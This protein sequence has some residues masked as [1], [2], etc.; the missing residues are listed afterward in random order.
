MVVLDDA[1]GDP[2]ALASGVAR[3]H[4]GDVGHVYRH[5][6]R[7]F[8]ARLPAPAVEA[9]RRHPRVRYVERDLPLHPLALQENAPWSLDRIDQR[10]TALDGRYRHWW[11]GAGVHLYVI[12]TGIEAQHPQFGGRVRHGWSAVSDGLGSGDCHGHG[13]AV[14]GA[15]GGASLGVARGAWLWSVRISGD[16]AAGMAAA[17]DAVRGL[18]WVAGNHQQPAVA[19][20]SFAG[21]PPG[22]LS[23]TFSRT[24]E[25][26][27]RGLVARGVV[28]V[29]GAGNEGVDACTQSPARLPEV[30]TV[31][32]TDR[33]DRR[34]V[35]AFGA[36]SNWGPCVDIWAPGSAVPSAERGG[37]TGA[38]SG[39]SLATAQVS[40]VAALLLEESPGLSV[41]A[42]RALLEAIATRT[43]IA[44]AG[45]GSP[46]RLLHALHLTTGILGPFRAE[47]P[48]RHVWTAYTTGGGGRPIAHLWEHRASGSAAWTPVG[49]GPTYARDVALWDPDFVLRVTVTVDGVSAEAVMGVEV[50]PGPGECAGP[51]GGGWPAVH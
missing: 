7:G 19:N 27:A 50:T 32:G 15:A 6:V 12:D 21:A 36:A 29:A 25:D 16:C 10:G 18:D 20:F 2:A 13:T 24:L 33:N 30:V 28:L 8:S 5:A 43:T 34:G 46:H 45:S 49:S 4:G 26:A 11:T 47:A 40:G 37:G 1:A 48:G 38:R 14:A 44:D 3:S 35:W 41:P 9:L 51:G 17:S 23:R 22:V 39:T 31:G 42:L